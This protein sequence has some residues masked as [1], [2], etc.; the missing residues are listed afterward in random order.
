MK[1]KIEKPEENVW[2][3][4]CLGKSKLDEAVVYFYSEETGVVIEQSTTYPHL[5]ISRE[6]CME[7]FNPVNSSINPKENPIDWDKVELPIWAMLYKDLTNI[8]IIKDKYIKGAILHNSG[9]M[10]NWDYT[11][12]SIKERDEYLNSLEILPKGT[13]I[14]IEL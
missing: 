9:D 13:K 6:F 7:D 12:Q 8:T 11:Y 5:Y 2:K 10:T 14:T 1:I 4:P 3:F